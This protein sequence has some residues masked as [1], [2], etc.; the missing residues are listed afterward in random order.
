MFKK[1]YSSKIS[2]GQHLKELVMRNV[3]NLMTLS[4]IVIL[5]PIVTL[6]IYHHIR[7]VNIKIDFAFKH[8]FVDIDFSLIDE[9][10]EAR[11]ENVLRNEG[12]ENA[13]RSLIWQ[14]AM[15][16]TIQLYWFV[17]NPALR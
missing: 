12:R 7:S 10:I 15:E 6:Y 2:H 5:G 17:T 11:N 13:A 16:T 1:L 3:T 4:A 9:N 8:I 14:T